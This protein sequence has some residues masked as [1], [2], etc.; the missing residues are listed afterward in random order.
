MLLVFGIIALALFAIVA[1]T[2]LVIVITLGPD[3]ADWLPE[4]DDM[5][6]DV[7]FL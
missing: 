5:A 3:S 7:Y 1:I 2:L 4:Y 6:D